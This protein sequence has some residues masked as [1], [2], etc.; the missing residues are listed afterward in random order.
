MP[1]AI[2]DFFVNALNYFFMINAPFTII[3]V[4]F[5]IMLF[6]MWRKSGK[7]EKIKLE[8]AIASEVFNAQMDHYDDSIGELE[9]V[10]RSNFMSLR[11]KTLVDQK[12]KDKDVTK[13]EYT[14]IEKQ[15]KSTLGNDS[16]I[17]RFNEILGNVKTSIKP[18]F[19]RIYKINHL[20][21]KKHEEFEN[22]ISARVNHVIAKFTE[23]LD[24]RYWEGT[25]P[26]RVTLYD[27]QQLLI[28]KCEEI[29][30]NILRHG[31]AI[32]IEYRK[33]KR[34]KNEHFITEAIK[35]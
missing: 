14:K 29:L 28:P 13:A 16:E 1:D 20:A 8:H 7:A 9:Q 10:L 5:G 24:E 21:D 23:E 4:I 27:S 19:R 2:I 34:L 25:Q 11:K 17:H 15:I 3:L 31:R 22:H 18:I 35:G 6:S 32:S 12:I 30:K 26:D 33:D